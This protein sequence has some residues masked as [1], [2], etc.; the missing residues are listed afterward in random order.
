MFHRITL[1]SLIFL[2]TACAVPDQVQPPAPAPPAAPSRP[3]VKLPSAAAVPAVPKAGKPGPIPTRPL[4]V[5][6]EC[7]FRDETGYN[8]TI[9]LAIEQ[10]RVEAFAANV[11]VPRRGN[12]SFDLK[13]FRQT[14][15]LPNVELTHLR[16]RCVVHVWEQ[17][18]RVTVAF[19]QCQKM[20]SGNAWEGLWPILTDRRDGS[21]A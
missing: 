16:D 14:R 12:C 4:N 2:A 9:K 17:G 5:R 7:T 6:A 15:A 3:E 20:C 1:L 8:G 21:C 11:N 10:A 18:D 19:Q 13:N